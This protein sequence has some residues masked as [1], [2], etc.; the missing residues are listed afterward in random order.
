IDQ[1]LRYC[2][3][4]EGTRVAEHTAATAKQRPVLSAV[5][6]AK[7]ALTVVRVTGQVGLAGA[8]I[9]DVG[10]HGIDRN[11]TNRQRCLMIGQWLPRWFE[12]ERVLRLPHAPL[13]AA[14][15]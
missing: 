11:G 4:D 7:N 5:D 10:I 3:A 12:A 1:N 13:C 8:H 15:L 6:R 9:D 2:L 14:R